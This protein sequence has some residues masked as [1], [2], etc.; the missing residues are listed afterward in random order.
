MS[1][2]RNVIFLDIDGVL[3]SMDYFT[4][5]EYINQYRADGFRDI[6]ENK[7]ILLKQLCDKSKAT[8]ILSSTWR[9]LIGTEYYD[10]LET[11]LAK[12]SLT[13]DSH[14]P[15]LDYNRPLEI[16]TWLD[17]H[18]DERIKYVSLD[19]DFSYEQY[20]VYGLGKC[21]VKTSFYDGGLKQSHVDLALQILT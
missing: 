7:V 10:Y 12:Y 21:L 19:D 13:I 18:A 5:A 6:D 2:Y 15:K 17:D 4:S 9:G 8:L 3:N 14:L 16:K 1:K 20:D 11:T